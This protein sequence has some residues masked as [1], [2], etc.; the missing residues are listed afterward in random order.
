MERHEARILRRG[1]REPSDLIA[2]NVVRVDVKTEGRAHD[3]QQHALSAVPAEH[4]RFH[5]AGEKPARHTHLSED[6]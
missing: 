5:S 2:V 3:M 6:L 1:L 4:G